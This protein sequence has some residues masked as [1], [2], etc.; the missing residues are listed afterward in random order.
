MTQDEFEYKEELRQNRLKQQKH[1]KDYNSERELCGDC[2]AF[3]N[4]H[5]YCPNCDY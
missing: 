2:G 3:L 5:D 4:C 1:N